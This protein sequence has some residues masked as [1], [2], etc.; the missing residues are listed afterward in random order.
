[1]ADAQGNVVKRK[2]P[3]WMVTAI[4]V[5]VIVVL[6]GVYAF[7]TTPS[8]SR[9]DEVTVTG[10]VVA[11]GVGLERITFTNIACGEESVAVISLTGGGSGVYSVSL[12][13]GYSYNVSIAWTGGEVDLDVLVLDTNERS[14]V[15]DWAVP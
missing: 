3:R 14:V 7:L 1:M 8:M 9:P 12:V 10:T 4:S 2:V 6:L 11:S 13:N 15:R 5:A